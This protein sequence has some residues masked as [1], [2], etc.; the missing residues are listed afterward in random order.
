MAAEIQGAIDVNKTAWKV[1]RTSGQ[2]GNTEQ[3]MDIAVEV[4]QDFPYVSIIT[5][6]APSPDWF[7]GIMKTSLCDSSTG[8]W[9]DSLNIDKLSPWD[10]GTDNG[11]RFNSNNIETVP[12]GYITIITKDSDTDFMNLTELSSIP[13]LGQL[14]FNRTNKPTMTQCSGEQKY[15]V[16]VEALWSKENHMNGFPTAQAHFSPLVIATH[17]YRYKFWSDMTRASPGVKIVAETGTLRLFD[18]LHRVYFS[19]HG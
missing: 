9:M 6:I 5:M 11:T 17:T 2:I 3:V 15:M 7:T 14:M 10:A 19:L 18:S 16:K 8:K 12:P 13:T 4:T 1:I